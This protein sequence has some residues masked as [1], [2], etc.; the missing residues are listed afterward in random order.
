M[1]L[2]PANVSCSFEVTYDSPSL[3]V[4]MSVFD[5][6]AGS[7]VLVLGPIAM[8]HVGNN[9]YRAKYTPGLNKL[10][11]IIKAVYT[12]VGLTIVDDN[13]SQGSE[14]VVSRDLSGGGGGGSGGCYVVGRVDNNN[15]VVGQVVCEN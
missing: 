13:Y 7:P 14:S 10:Y 3:H 12:D 2:A 9:T 6:S 15:Q 1:E 11:V 4:G 8:A 5:D